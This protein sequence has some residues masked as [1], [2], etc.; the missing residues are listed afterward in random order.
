MKNNI[1]IYLLIGCML[2]HC[3]ENESN[4]QPDEKESTQ[5]LVKTPAFNADTAYYYIEKQLSFGPRVP[6]S[7]AHQAC[8]TYLLETLD[9]MGAAIEVQNFTVTSY[10]QL[11]LQGKNIIASINPKAEKRILLA[12]H[13][14]TRRIAD[15]EK[16]EA[17][18]E[19]PIDGANDGASGVAVILEIIRTI[20]MAADKPQ[21]GIDVILFDL[22]DDGVPEGMAYEG[23]NSE[24]WC[25]GS[26]HWSN[27]K[28]R[29]NYTAYYGI[30]LDM[31]G[32]KGAKFKKEPYS[33]AY[34]RGV[35]EKVWGIAQRLGYGNYFLNQTIQM[36]SG[37][38]ILDDHYFVNVDA[39]IPMI[40]IID[41]D[42]DFGAFHHTQEDNISIIDKKTLKAVGQTVL[43]VIYQE[44][45][46]FE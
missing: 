31:V 28:H 41:Y 38:G 11:E 29:P 18:R 13:W 43:Q 12:A 21:V 22:E 3:K 8:A 6:N 17:K 23:D 15:K 33:M 9:Q 44:S 4:E 2:W 27:N 26:R 5:P 1:W 32:G 40:D 7:E 25:H 34:A 20:Q 36:P 45:A 24:T 14:D 19:Q 16:D 10:D 46:G 42:E 35:V 30:L 39:K 37:Y